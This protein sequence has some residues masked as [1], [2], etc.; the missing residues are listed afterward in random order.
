MPIGNCDSHNH[1]DRAK[2]RLDFQSEGAAMTSFA[3]ALVLTALAAA[4]GAAPRGLL[5]QD[6]YK[7]VTIEDA[8]LSPDGGLIA[9]TV[10]KIDEAKN[11]R[12]RSLWLQRLKNG[13]AEGEAYQFTAPTAN[14]ASPVWSPDGNVLSF[15]S[16]RGDD[17]NTTW[18]MRVTAPGGEAYHIE[19]VEGVPLWSPEGTRIAFLKEP[20]DDEAAKD[21]AAAAEKKPEEAKKKE[22]EGWVS[23]EA[24][25]QTLDAKRFDGRV[26]TT[27]RMKRDGTLALL[28]HVSAKKKKQIYIV[29]ARG[30]T[31]TK[32]TDLAF[33]PE[34]L[35]WTRDGSTILFTGDEK[36][37]DEYNEDYT[38]DIYAVPASGGAPR[39]LSSGLGS[40]RGL[41]ISPDGKRLA[42]LF[43]ERP[44][45]PT[46]VYT[47]EISEA[48]DFRGAPANLTASWDLDPAGLDWAGS[49][50][51]LRW[52]AGVGGNRH[53]FESDLRGEVRPLTQGDRTLSAVTYAKRARVMAYAS[54]DAA[55]PTELFVA[56]KDGA[57][58]SRVTN[59]NDAW[60]SSL[61][62]MPAERLS[63]KVGDGTE[64]EGWLIKPAGYTAG[65]KYPMILKIHGGPHTAY[66]NYWFHMFHV[67]SN[68]GF[69]VL[70]TNPRG[71]TG[72]GHEFTY[73]TRGRWGEMDSEDFLAGVDAA[74]A[75]NADIDPERIGVSGGS[76]GGYMTAWLTA[77][78][79][80][81]AV[82][83][84]SRMICNWESWYG[85]SDAQ[86]LTEFEFNGEPWEMR[87]LYQRLSPLSY[88][89]KVYTPTLI[90][91]GENDY[92]TPTADSEQWYMALKKRGVPVEMTLYPRS[93]HEL[94]RSG[95][96]WL[97]V[98]RL[99]RIKTW[100]EHWLI[101]EKLTRT[102]AKKRYA[103]QELTLDVL[104]N[105]EF[106]VT[107]SEGS[108]VKLVDGL[109]E[110]SEPVED[111]FYVRATDT[112]AFGDFDGDEAKDAAIVLVSNTGGS[113]VFEDIV[114]VRGTTGAPRVS[115]A[116]LL[117]DRVKVQNIVVTRGEILVD[118]I[119]QGP[120]D[121]M[122]CPTE[123]ATRRFRLDRDRLIE[124]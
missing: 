116:L 56:Q 64:I 79:D 123:R 57:K 102:E 72:Y 53:L 78:T 31:A 120:N 96:P 114:L 118:L 1:Y 85:A 5:P 83:N 30:G 87:E 29:D 28:P 21:G 3:I 23:P 65:T 71:S 33:D 52:S 27:M 43:A 88:V 103:R 121:P 48:G 66:G 108:P 69:F 49:N 14:A 6:V 117:G 63:W 124:P 10:M 104:K 110:K 55:H 34:D 113:G 90:I 20:K 76:Y 44:G 75:A 59:F 97:M 11:E 92:R 111:R 4:D 84:P 7:E 54:N 107:A 73:A 98:D 62:L 112:V 42:Y 16:K 93:G 74:L 109:Y 50:R 101:E 91:Q 8:A 60:L 24:I 80:R 38:R 67:L 95:E 19:G 81:F 39:K 105:L 36:Q 77:T 99:N 46:D 17:E 122:C 106:G 12:R 15:Q 37:D 47:V 82:A 68:A 13:G 51:D 45:T 41:A 61:T 18:F 25:S 32:L 35:V 26:F 86:R 22:R 89:E 58:E 119:Q 2:G 40:E 9:F 100:F 115:N 70:Y 94:S